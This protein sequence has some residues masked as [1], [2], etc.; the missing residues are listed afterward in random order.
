MRKI[1]AVHIFLAGVFTM[2]C[3]SN[4]HKA[5]ADVTTLTPPAEILNDEGYGNEDAEYYNSEDNQLNDAEAAGSQE[6]YVQNEAIGNTDEEP[7][8]PRKKSLT[9]AE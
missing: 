5:K 6:M 3:F 1:R 9:D 7:S 4:A 8:G 2:I